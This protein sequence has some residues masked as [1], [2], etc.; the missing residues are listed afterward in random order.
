LALR[1]D[2]ADFEDLRAAADAV[3]RLYTQAMLGAKVLHEARQRLDARLRAGGTKPEK[4]WAIH[5]VDVEARTLELSVGTDRERG[6]SLF[7]LTP[8]AIVALA[9]RAPGPPDRMALALGALALLPPVETSD[10]SLSPSLDVRGT[11][12]GYEEVQRGLEGLPLSAAILKHVVRV[13]D[14]LEKER[15]KNEREAAG[16]FDG[17]TTNFRLNPPRLSSAWDRLQELLRDRRL[18]ATDFYAENEADIL[19]LKGIME[20]ETNRLK[21]ARWFPGA[22][23]EQIGPPAERVWS[24]KYD[25]DTDDQLQIANFAAGKG[26][27]E[28]YTGTAVIT[29]GSGLN[30]RLH[31]L[32]GFT[33]PSRDHPL[34]W[35]SIFD[36][37]API[38]VTFDLFAFDTPY[39]LAIDVDGHQVA[40]L[41]LDPN[42]YPQFAF[43]PD[44]P[45]LEGEKRPPVLDGQGRGRGVAFHGGPDF[46]DLKDWAER[47]RLLGTE[48]TPEGRGRH[49]GEWTKAKPGQRLFA[50]EPESRNPG[51]VYKVKVVRER[52]KITLIVDNVVVAAETREEWS[53]IGSGLPG[54]G[55]S[56]GTGLIQIL[57]W[58]PMAIDDLTFHG[59]VKRSWMDE[60]ERKDAEQDKAQAGPR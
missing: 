7:A 6:V 28:P 49:H 42:W 35:R 18:L 19:R 29:P 40:V 8:A 17:A 22:H 15:S 55:I 57:T 31:L 24:V 21:L 36:P 30:Q 13:V 20:N 50:F 16:L 11:K 23:V 59:T 44:V 1:G 4:G 32:R 46:G 12:A 25:L 5:A 3:H 10:A 51:H 47:G 37:A 58:T 26:V 53:R 60:Q 45:L 34:V 52:G 38:T 9:R 39:L 27:L 56:N 33:E 54:S 41:S 14:R 43:P 48:W 2:A